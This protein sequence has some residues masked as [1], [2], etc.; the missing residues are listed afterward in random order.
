MRGQHRCARLGCTELVSNRQFACPP[1][2]AQLSPHVQAAI[3]QTAGL[4]ILHP[5]RR[6]AIAA[7]R[8][9]WESP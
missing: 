2:W 5:D 6:A 9:E 1:H 3:Y 8:D 4:L 7:A